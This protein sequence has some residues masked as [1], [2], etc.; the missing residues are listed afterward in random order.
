VRRWLALS[1]IA[2]GLL[3]AFGCAKPKVWVPPRIDLHRYGTLGLVEFRSGHGHG[4][5]ATQRFL[6]TVHAAQAGVPVLELGSLEGVLRSVG[7]EAMGPEAARAIGERY[8]V[9]A[10]V[11]GDLDIDPPRPNF[12]VQSFTQANA[13]AEILGT[14]NARIMDV[15]S[16]ATIWSNEARGKRTVAH[17]NMSAGSRPQFGAVDPDGEHAKLV[18][19]LVDRIT[20]DFRGRWARQ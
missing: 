9:R 7:H 16:G 2:I 5:M 13:S 10:L 6:A 17:L 20:G 12:S 11:I 14:L 4:P 18:A 8:A 1:G 19:W 15:R 3:V